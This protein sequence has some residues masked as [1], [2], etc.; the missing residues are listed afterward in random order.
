MYGSVKRYIYLIIGILIGL[1]LV[2]NSLFYVTWSSLWE[3]RDLK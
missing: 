1:Y 3:M 2:E